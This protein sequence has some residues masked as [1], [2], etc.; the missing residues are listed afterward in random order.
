M[1]KELHYYIAENKGQYPNE[2]DWLVMSK[3]KGMITS[4]RLKETSQLHVDNNNERFPDGCVN[5][6]RVRK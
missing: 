1:A 4:H 2:L 3:T 6:Y 5:S